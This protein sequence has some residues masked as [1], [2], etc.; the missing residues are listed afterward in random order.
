MS[1][2]KTIER[3]KSGTV[4]RNELDTLRANA[5]SRRHLPGAQELLAAIQMA[6]PLNTYMVFMGFCPNAEFS[7]RLDLEWKKQG[8]CTFDYYED[9]VQ[10]ARFNSI[11]PGDIIVLKKRE[12]FG[13]SMKVYGHGIVTSY[14]YDS[15][16]RRIL[17]VTWSD[18]NEVIET[19]LMGANS[20]VNIKDMSVI[21]NEM[22]EQF[23]QWLQV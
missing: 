17:N 8:T 4:S 13:V 19:P 21:N 12:V 2:Q 11:M 18:Q 23:F 16:N 20:T 1:I 7:N 3:I 5:E 6:K 9:E 10:S 15:E 14:A 22:P